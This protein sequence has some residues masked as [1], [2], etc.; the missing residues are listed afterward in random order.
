[1]PRKILRPLVRHHVDGAGVV[2]AVSPHKAE[3]TA[4]QLQR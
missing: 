1:V 4:A 3:W 2:N